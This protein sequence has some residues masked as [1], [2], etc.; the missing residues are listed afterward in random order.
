M[1]SKAIALSVAAIGLVFGMGTASAVC[2]QE[3]F[4]QYSTH[5][6]GGIPQSVFYLDAATGASGAPSPTS[7]TVTV[8]WGTGGSACDA[9]NPLG[10]EG[11]TWGLA[12]QG[13]HLR[14]RVVGDAATCP[15]GGAIR[16]MGCFQGATVY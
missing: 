10:P 8:G 1:K 12:S 14:V 11:T 4:I 16:N 6:A 2:I 7:W 15:T 3:G 13:N 5:G 9:T